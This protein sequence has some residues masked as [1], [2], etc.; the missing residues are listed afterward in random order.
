M[1]QTQEQKL[2]PSAAALLQR[3][4]IEAALI[5]RCWEDDAFK[6]KLLADPKGTVEAAFRIGLPAGVTVRVQEESADALVLSLPARPKAGELSDVDLEHVAGGTGKV[7]RFPTTPI[8]PIQCTQ[9]QGTIDPV[10]AQPT[11]LTNPL[12]GMSFNF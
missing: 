11:H 3:K 12:V 8:G 7:P 4:Q 2:S 6:K 5:A 9:K 10:T 1:S